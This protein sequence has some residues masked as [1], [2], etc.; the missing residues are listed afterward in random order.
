MKVTIRKAEINDLKAIQDLNHK[1]FLWDY[2]RDPA[3]NADWPYSQAGKDYFTKRINSE[4]GV[5]F[6]AEQN[7][8]IIGY[9]AG[10]VSK[11]IDKTDT[12]LR[13]ELENIYIE[14]TARSNGIGRLLVQSLTKWCK[15][16][17]AQSMFV[18][19]YYHNNDAISFYRACGFEPF[20]LKLEKRL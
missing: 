14:D 10:R 3:L 13:S 9:V 18:S 15:D 20:V 4:P 6:V 8:I 1:L 19:S 7:N 17:G 11:E 5:C 2:G 12:I 16:Q